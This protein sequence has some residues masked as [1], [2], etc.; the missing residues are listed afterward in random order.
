MTTT[1]TVP[2]RQP[3]H[4]LTTTTTLQVV[5]CDSRNDDDTPPMPQHQC[6]RSATCVTKTTITQPAIS[7]SAPVQPPQG[8]PGLL[9]RPSQ[10]IQ[11]PKAHLLRILAITPLPYSLRNYT[12]TSLL[13]SQKSS[14]QIW[15]IV[16]T[17]AFSC[18][19]AL[20]AMSLMTSSNSKSGSNCYSNI[21]G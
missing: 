8:R 15:M 6:Q 9:L 17:P 12:A 19:R 13:S 20:A 4:A 3:R 11:Q 7:S 16:P 2:R 21:N 18:I 14:Q 10:A 5:R 1:T